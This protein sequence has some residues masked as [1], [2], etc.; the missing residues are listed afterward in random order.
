MIE[1]I[2]ITWASI[3][4]LVYLF[5]WFESDPIVSPGLVELLLF[6]LAGPLSL[7]SICK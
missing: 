6:L 5:H 2:F 4:L 1:T 3:G 7:V